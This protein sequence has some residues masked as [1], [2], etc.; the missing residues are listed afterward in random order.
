VSELLVP[1]SDVGEFRKRFKWM[2]LFA[3]LAFGAITVRLFQLQVLSGAEYAA[4]A[5]ENIVHRVSLPTSRGVIRDALGKVLASSRPSYNLYVIP[6]RVMPSAR[7]VHPGR[8]V[9]EEGTDTWPHIAEVLRL[10]P[11]DRGRFDAR[12]RGACA[13]DEDKSPCWRPI[14]VKEDL[15]RDLVAEVRQHES[16]LIGAETVGVPVRYYP[17]K[18]LAAHTIGY[19]SEIDSETLRKYRPDDFESLSAEEK[20]RKNPLS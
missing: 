12:I 8:A 16:E 2:V 10:N 6:G 13:S 18:S 20:Q 5:H 11:E 1:R 7:P 19:T 15:S 14:L 4:I 17:Y 9:P 3:F